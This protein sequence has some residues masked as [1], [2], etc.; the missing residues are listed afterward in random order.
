MW[1]DNEPKGHFYALRLHSLLPM[2][3]CMWFPS[4][5]KIFWCHTC[6]QSNIYAY[7]DDPCTQSRAHQI[8]DSFSWRS[9]QSNEQP[10]ITSKAQDG[11]DTWQSRQKLPS[12]KSIKIVKAHKGLQGTTYTTPHHCLLQYIVV[13]GPQS[14]T[15]RTSGKSPRLSGIHQ[16]CCSEC[17]NCS[18]LMQGSSLKRVLSF[19]Q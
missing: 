2:D 16:E 6:M 18:Y 11:S 5:L 15:Y 13:L 8:V 9:C 7:F 19:S 12:W 3:E 1:N 10:H 14:Q 4:A 17:Q